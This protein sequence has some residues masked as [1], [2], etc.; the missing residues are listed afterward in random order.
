LVGRTLA[1]RYAL[2]TEIADGPI[3]KLFAAKDLLTGRALSIRL[4][5]NTFNQEPSL[6]SAILTSMPGL[7]VQHPALERIEE[8]AESDG[9]HFLIGEL[10]KGSPLSERVKHFAPFS[11]P[12]GLATTI[13]LCEALVALHAEG[14]VHGDVGTHNV[15]A[16]HDGG[17]KLQ[18]AGIWRAY[19]SSKTAGLA[20]LPQMCYYLAPELSNGGSPSVSSDLYALGVVM[21]ILLTGRYPFDGGSPTGT[22][23]RHATGQIPSA[24][25]LNPSVPNSVDQF[26]QRILSKNPAQRP[27]S[28]SECLTEMRKLS[29]ALRF[30][31][32]SNPKLQ[33]ET[34]ALSETEETK[35]PAKTAKLNPREASGPDG[36]APA[37]SAI[38]TKPSKKIKEERDVPLWLWGIFGLFFLTMVGFIGFW[39]VNSFQKPKMISVPNLSGLS[40]VEA[41]DVG[42]KLKLSVRISDREA[43]DRV[44]IEKIIRAKPNAGGKLREGGTVY[45]T[46]STGSK[47]IILPKIIGMTVDEAK[48]ILAKLNLEID[49]DPIPQPD[50]DFP[51]GIII[52]QLP[53]ASQKIERLTPIRVW[54]AVPQANTFRG[55][56]SP[57]KTG[58]LN[59]HHLSPENH[60]FEL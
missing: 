48:S 30:G 4:L 1:V 20:V 54:V 2:S 32:S 56:P 29:D 27:T 42:K 16:T 24:R 9:Q 23:S 49:G 53:E 7:Q 60:S 55:R 44:D 6:V 51:P 5:Q 58:L 10:P 35:Q 38:R 28:A 31:R 8:F 50:K 34:L 21:F 39:V 15:I 13:C 14:V 40:F 41:Q 3:F 52:R 11:V 47:F 19:A 36:V 33:A 59:I 57:A 46:M 18:M 22:V 25:G 26:I 17:A 37:M 45:V 12:V 43:S